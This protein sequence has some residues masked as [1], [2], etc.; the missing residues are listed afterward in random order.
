MGK[1]QGIEKLRK[2]LESVGYPLT[3]EKVNELMASRK[4]PHSKSYGKTIIFDLSHIDWWVEEQRKT[5]RI[6]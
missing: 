5:E 6:T 4:I 1:I 2:Y 3:E